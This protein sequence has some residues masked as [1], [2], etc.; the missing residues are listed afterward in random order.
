MLGAASVFAAVGL[1]QRQV[2]LFVRAA[3]I[4]LRHFLRHF[5][6][7]ALAGTQEQSPWVESPHNADDA[8]QEWLVAISL[9]VKLNMAVDVNHRLGCRGS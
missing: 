9:W 8:T 5:Q 3:G 4:I 6:H 7:R 1:G 2:R